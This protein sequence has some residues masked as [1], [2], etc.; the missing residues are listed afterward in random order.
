MDIVYKKSAPVSFSQ[1]DLHHEVSLSGIF[2]YLQDIAIEHADQYNTGTKISEELGETWVLNRIAVEVLNYPKY[3][4][5]LE[6]STW[7]TGIKSFKGFRDLRIAANGKAAIKAS[8]LWLYINVANKSIVRVPKETAARFPQGDEPSYFENLDKLKLS[9][10]GPEAQ[11]VEI[12]LRYTDIDA[13]NHI[14]NTA[15]PAFLQT[16]LHKLGENPKPTKIEMQ[17]LKEISPDQQSVTVFI[18]KKSDETIFS[19]GNEDTLFAIGRCSN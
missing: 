6:F 15:Y 19:I 5:Q 1:V 16:A 9:K 4:D 11:Q 8:T 12:S 18:E 17:Y 7:S 2:Q 3:P 10:P 13:N 14:N